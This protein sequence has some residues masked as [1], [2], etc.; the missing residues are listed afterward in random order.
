MPTFTV[1]CPFTSCPKRQ[2]QIK[3]CYKWKCF[4]PRS[5]TKSIATKVRC[6]PIL[7][8]RECQAHGGDDR[9]AGTLCTM[10][11]YDGQVTDRH[12][13]GLIKNLHPM[14][15]VGYIVSDGYDVAHNAICF[16][17]QFMGKTVY[18]ITARTKKE[19]ISPAN[20]PFIEN[21]TGN[22][23]VTAEMLKRRKK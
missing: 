20:L 2:I 15:E 5:R 3:K 22:S 18:D 12:Y 8:L 23:C 4:L 17:C 19:S 16:L 1:L 6:S 14:N 13:I 11:K 21:R 10:K 9:F 7:S